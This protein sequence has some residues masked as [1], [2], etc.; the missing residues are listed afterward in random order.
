MNAST[1]SLP[2]VARKETA[3]IASACHRNERIHCPLRPVKGAKLSRLDQKIGGGKPAAYVCGRNVTRSEKRDGPLSFA[4]SRRLVAVLAH[5]FPSHHLA[6]CG[7]K[8]KLVIK[9]PLGRQAGNPEEK[10]SEVP[11]EHIL[12]N[13]EV[14]HG[15]L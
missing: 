2:H 7:A 11:S 3:S 15:S 5:S 1:L 9:P 13:P 4:S 12:R 6:L 8:L 10:I 14:A